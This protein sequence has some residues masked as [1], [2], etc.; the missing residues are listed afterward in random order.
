[1][2]PEKWKIIK[3][4]VLDNFKQVE[5]S[6]EELEEPEVGTVEIL[7]FTG[8]LGR[9]RLEY[10]TRPVVLDKVTHG[11]RRIGS[12]HTVEYVYAPDE[13]SHSLK[14]HKWDEGKDDWVEIDLRGSFNL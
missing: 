3:G 9:M 10:F 2:S 13:F 12:Q 8:P 7:E 14:A 1:M 4:Q 5:Q 11:S 6:S